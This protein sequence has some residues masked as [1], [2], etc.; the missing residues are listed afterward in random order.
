MG[1]YYDDD[2]RMR[3]YM[4]DDDMYMRDNYMRDNYMRNNYMRDDGYVFAGM[5]QDYDDFWDSYDN[6]DRLYRQGVRG[7][8]RYGI[9]GSRY[10]GRRYRRMDESPEYNR[11]YRRDDYPFDLASTIHNMVME[12]KPD[13]KEILMSWVKEMENADG[14]KGAHFS[15]DAIKKLY[16]EENIK[17]KGIEFEDYYATM[18]MFYSDFDEV[19]K[20]ADVSNLKTYSAMSVAF[21]KDKDA[22][23]EKV[24]RYALFIPKD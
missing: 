17:D 6:P 13:K 8:G 2:R 23:S 1:R 12:A 9:G 11:E 15:E 3:R 24:L 14:S 20:K 7:T 5:I 18:N 16:E 19:M 4:R 10:P 22:A 21:I